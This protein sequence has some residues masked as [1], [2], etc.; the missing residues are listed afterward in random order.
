MLHRNVEHADA[1][2]VT[3]VS[4]CGSSA[5]VVARATV[6]SSVNILYIL[7]GDR[8]QRL[9]A[10]F[11]HYLEGV[12]RQVGKWRAQVRELGPEESE[13]HGIA[14]D[15]RL[16]ANTTLRRVVEALGGDEQERWP[17]SIGERFRHIGDSLGYRT[18]YA[19][20][21]VRESD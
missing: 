9:R 12:D 8:T 4:G 13:I 15:R 19:R 10:Y 16:A 14:I 18:F 5:E 7:A 11:N 3:F 2:I 17:T 1:A 6:E 20:M 21:W